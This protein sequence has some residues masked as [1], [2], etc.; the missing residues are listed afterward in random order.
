[1][2]Y[3]ILVYGSDRT[4]Q[5]MAMGDGGGQALSAAELAEI[6]N[7]VTKFTAD[8]AESGELV[9]THGLTTPAQAR[10]VRL[11]DAGSVVTDGPYAETEEVL[12]GFWIVDVASIDRATELAARLNTCPGPASSVG[13]IIRP[14]LRSDE[15]DD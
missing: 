2:K 1:M 8:L 12:A 15:I 3:M 10:Q 9:D 13:A 5:T 7:F 14:L 6:G 4:Y 11:T